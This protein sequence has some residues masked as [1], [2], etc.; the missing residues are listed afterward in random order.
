MP[1]LV[2]NPE[3]RFSCV[4]AHFFSHSS[5]SAK[6]SRAFVSCCER[7]MLKNRV[8]VARIMVARITN[9]SSITLTTEHK[10]KA[11]DP[12]VKMQKVVV[13]VE[14]LNRDIML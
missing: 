5:S 3:D 14:K 4:T 6:I 13:P 8:T 12:V 1:N 10:R 11:L 2:G 9:S 7:S